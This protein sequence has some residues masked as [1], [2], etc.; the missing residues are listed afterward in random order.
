L[1]G[2][3]CAHLSLCEVQDSG[4]ASLLRHLE[5]SAAAGLLNVVAMRGD[6]KNIE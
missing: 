2:A 3:A 5:Q 6:S 4:A 1:G